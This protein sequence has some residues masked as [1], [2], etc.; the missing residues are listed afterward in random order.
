MYSI[1]ARQMNRDIR[2][3]H[4]Y[5]GRM[6]SMMGAVSLF[7]WASNTKLDANWKNWTHIAIV[8]INPVSRT[9]PGLKYQGWSGIFLVMRLILGVFVLI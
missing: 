8:G 5:C 9:Q 3:D 6:D 7:S 2:G 1:H 4:Y